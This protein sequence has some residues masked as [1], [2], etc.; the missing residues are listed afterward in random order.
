MADLIA[1]KSEGYA[2]ELPKTWF[3]PSLKISYFQELFHFLEDE[4]EA[5]ILFNAQIERA[6]VH[7]ELEP[8]TNEYA[9]LKEYSLAKFQD[10]NAASLF[11]T[12]AVFSKTA[13]SL[14]NNYLALGAT[15]E[16]SDRQEA[17]IKRSDSLL[18]NYRSAIG[19]LLL[20]N[21]GYTFEVI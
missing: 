15:K 5:A 19:Q 11:Y 20:T 3:Y 12:Q 13:S 10:E 9:S 4:T 1:D 17:L 2:G 14:I 16:A 18:V 6:I 7:R 8:L 21:S